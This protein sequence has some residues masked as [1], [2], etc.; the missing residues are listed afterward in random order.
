MINADDGVVTEVV[1]P[2]G[3]YFSGSIDGLRPRF[4]GGAA[5]SV[6]LSCGCARRGLVAMKRVPVRCTELAQLP[7]GY[8][9]L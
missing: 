4:A 8:N 7:A 5:G 9:F 2:Q 3:L 1:D 6:R